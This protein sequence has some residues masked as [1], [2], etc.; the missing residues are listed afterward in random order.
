MPGTQHFC[1]FIIPCLTNPCAFDC[2]HARTVVT[3]VALLC[4]SVPGGS[5]CL[6]CYTG[7]WAVGGRWSAGRRRVLAFPDLKKGAGGK[8]CGMA[9]ASYYRRLAMPHCCTYRVRRQEDRSSLTGRD[10]NPCL[11]LPHWTRAC[12]TFGL[13][14]SSLTY[15]SF[16]TT[17]GCNVG[18]IISTVMPLS[19][20]GI[21]SDTGALVIYASCH[22]PPCKQPRGT[23]RLCPSFQLNLWWPSLFAKR[24]LLV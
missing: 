14:P 6:L 19:T 2:A 9:G 12:R 23:V 7:I 13:L 11:L 24:D 21:Y 4:S 10:A 5:L 18:N 1:G 17:K 8:R 22:V 16:V 20:S 15:L 3:K